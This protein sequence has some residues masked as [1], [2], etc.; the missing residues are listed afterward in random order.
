MPV[1]KVL[2]LDEFLHSHEPVDDIKKINLRFFPTPYR[3]E[4]NDKACKLLFNGFTKK[5]Y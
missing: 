5:F 2:S 3:V 1:K 4:V